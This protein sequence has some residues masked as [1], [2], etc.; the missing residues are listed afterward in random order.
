VSTTDE[1]ARYIIPCLFRSPQ[2]VDCHR[3]LVDAIADRFGLT[4]T[5]RQGIPAHFT[6]KYHFTTSEIGRVEELLEEL[7]S[8]HAPAPLEVGGLG[9]FGEEVVFVEV[10]LSDDAKRVLTALFAALRTL[11]WMPWSAHDAEHLHPHMT[12]AEFCRPKFPE[13]WEFVK[14]RERRFTTALDNATIL[15]QVGEADGVDRWAV[16][17][18]FRLGL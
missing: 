16:H 13:V 17:R 7:A 18:S 4:F 5:Q 12:V 6:L 9:H 1:P 2:I 15:R 14:A 3:E 10:R 11:A 8:R